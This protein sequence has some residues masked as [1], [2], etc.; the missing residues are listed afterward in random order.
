MTTEQPEGTE[1]VSAAAQA[2]SQHAFVDPVEERGSL[3]E[4]LRVALPL[5]ISSGSVSLMHVVDR[6]FL[7]WWSVDALAASLPSGVLFWAVLSLPF[8]IAVYTNTFVAQY[9][10]A[11]RKERVVA[12]VWQG[13]W[14][15]VAG[16]V[17][18]GAC[19]PFSETVFRTWVDHEEAVLRLEASYFS[20]LC[21]GAVPTLVQ[22]ALS[23]FFSGRGQTTVVMWVNLFVS[24]LDGVL[25]YVMIFGKGP[26]P[27]MG[28]NGAA[29]STNIS[30]AVACLLF[31]GLLSWQARSDG[32][33]LWTCRRWDGELFFRLLRF[34]MPNGVQFLV[35]VGAFTLFVL[36]IG[37]IGKI[38]LAAT[39]LAFNLNSM[40]FIPMFG[41]GT[42]VMTLV[43]QRI[44]E[45]RPELAVRSTRLA[46]AL[47]GLYMLTFA[48]LYL[49]MPQLMLAP[50]AAYGD[51]ESF[52]HVRP[53]VVVLLRFVAFYSFFDAM[54]IVFG[55]AIRGAGDTRFSLWWTFGTSWLLMVLPAWLATAN[56]QGGLLAC[57]SAATI[58]IFVLGIGFA[59]RFRK[60]HW[61]TM[62][63]IERLP[64]D[65]DGIDAPH[66]HA[67]GLPG[68][69]RLPQ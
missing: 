25:N 62:S 34:G 44:G 54:A 17:L 36:F 33:P 63:V 10:G 12:S 2:A 22:V 53:V 43:G 47:S 61:Q 51:V 40:A 57:W 60:G 16:G 24:F 39:T 59:L 58:Y 6:M 26:F 4:L 1:P 23:A 5:V 48:F 27:E 41:L 14:L 37:R 35:D 20:I 52:D 28:M 21:L 7:T 45:G 68:A 50:Y 69:E 9:S 3:R 67:A 31:L 8:G 38:E 32:Y 19:A 55:S 15:A 13:V 65:A 56:G 66:R 29:W 49:A 46:F 18:V 30:Q 11:A 64:R 42:A